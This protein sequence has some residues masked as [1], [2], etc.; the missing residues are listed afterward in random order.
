MGLFILS[1]RERPD[2]LQPAW[3]AAHRR[4]GFRE[5]LRLTAG[6][7]RLD[8]FGALNGLGPQLV[9]R[10]N[11]DFAACTGVFFY[12]G[13]RGTAGLESLL[14]DFDGERFP[15]SGS[16]GHFAVIVCKAGRMF[17]ATDALG[18][19]KVYHDGGRTLLSSSFTALRANLAQALAAFLRHDQ[20][21]AERDESVRGKKEDKLLD[22]Q[23]AA[24]EDGQRRCRA[25]GPR[26]TTDSEG[27][28][29]AE[30]ERQRGDGE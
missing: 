11:G 9:Q 3:L 21:C 7:W 20:E 29:K 23:N 27:V 12:R 8:L 13:A 30:I 1:R 25:N 19:Y 28:G 24:D 26:P 17:L 10:D 6:D 16:R 14:D 4:H 18:G 2:P 15:W 22:R 5:P